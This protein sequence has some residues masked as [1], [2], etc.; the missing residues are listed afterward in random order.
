M[1]F[2]RSFSRSVPDCASSLKQ[3]GPSYA[4]ATVAVILIIVVI[5]A[6][7]GAGAYLI[8]MNGGSSTTSPS[9]NSSG[10]TSSVPSSSS[11]S[12]YSQLSSSSTT[13][14]SSFYLSN[15]ITSFKDLIGNFSQMT[16]EYE[17]S[18]GN[19]TLSYKV[20]GTY[21]INSTQL[22]ETNFTAISTS[23]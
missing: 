14:G 8:V 16:V 19:L 12:S 20:L 6:A 1:T 15:I 10:S 13:S 7:A 9:T 18:A 11:S 2:R 21:M 5:I 17:S 3:I 22:T 23:E 4:I